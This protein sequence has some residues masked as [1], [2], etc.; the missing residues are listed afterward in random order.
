MF[1]AITKMQSWATTVLTN[2]NVAPSE[3]PSV[4]DR[5]SCAKW[6]SMVPLADPARAT[7]ALTK[8]LDELQDSE[9]SGVRYFGILEQL[10][11][12]IMVVQGQVIEQL[13]GRGVPMQAPLKDAFLSIQRLWEQLARGYIR[14]F[15]EANQNDRALPHRKLI[16]RALEALS[17]MVLGHYQARQALPVAM[18]K[19]LHTMW[20]QLERCEQDAGDAPEPGVGE[21]TAQDIYVFNVLM[22]LADP[23]RLSPREL[24]IVRGWT[25]RWARKVTFSDRFE[26]GRTV[27]IDLASSAPPG[28]VR[29][30]RDARAL[31]LTHLELSLLKRMRAL[32]RGTQPAAMG[33]GDEV[34]PDEAADLVRMLHRRWCCAPRASTTTS[35]LRVMQ[36]A[37]RAENVIEP[38]RR[39]T[40]PTSSS[41][42]EYSGRG[43]DVYGM[44]ATAGQETKG[45]LEGELETWSLMKEDGPELEL[46][47][48]REGDRIAQGYLVGLRGESG[49]GFMLGRV[50][51]VI[52]LTD[53]GIRVGVRLFLGTNARVTL[54]KTSMRDGIS[55]INIRA[56][57][58]TST[59]GSKMVI[60]GLGKLEAGDHLSFR[61]DDT[62]HEGRVGGSLYRSIDFSG[63]ALDD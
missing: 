48:G 43:R 23:Y 55:P 33:L 4:R 50:D 3:L 12:A 32:Q 63:F 46:T 25:I 35:D 49:A 24:G 14:A 36:V 47:R 54:R 13:T 56:V 38:G 52:E 59:A 28:L 29:A 20:K 26:P 8:L 45:G 21:P 2:G 1:G 16:A 22:H 31:D 42:W 9:M 40:A 44:F 62:E 7:E 6:L 30:D 53:G 58:V 27:G 11:P 41:N 57:V 34:S 39:T 18:W 10:R 19:R 17:G 37:V 60:T 15:E 61:I 51:W 5:E